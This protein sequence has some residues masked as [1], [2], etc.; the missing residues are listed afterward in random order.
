MP[1][2][3][4][5]PYADPPPTRRAP[6]A[7][8]SA[9][10]VRA[11]VE[12]AVALPDGLALLR[13]APLECAAVLLGVDPRRLD[14][15]RAAL[16]DPA[17]FSEAVRAHA[18]AAGSRRAP[19]EPASGPTPPRDPSALLDAARGREGGVAVLLEA[20]AEVAAVVF[21]VH[22]ALVHRARELAARGGPSA[23]PRA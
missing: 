18:R 17:A 1:D 4:K 20:S 3:A 12:R 10:E 21:G 2:V 8:A 16:A 6:S 13:D 5:P 9:D 7:P 15:V 23:L 19:A 14:R 11:V 22:P